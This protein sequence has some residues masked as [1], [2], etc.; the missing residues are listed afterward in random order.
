MDLKDAKA[1]LGS[2]RSP[3]K[4]ARKKEERSAL[5]SSMEMLDPL[6]KLR[7]CLSTGV[8][9]PA[10]LLIPECI[11][12]A[13]QLDDCWKFASLLSTQEKI[14]DASGALSAYQILMRAQSRPQVKQWSKG[15]LSFARLWKAGTP[16]AQPSQATA[17]TFLSAVAHLLEHRASLADWTPSKG[18][19]P[20]ETLTTLVGISLELVEMYPTPGSLALGAELLAQAVSRHSLDLDE[21]VVSPETQENAGAADVLWRSLTAE[22][23]RAAIAIRLGDLQVLL[24]AMD[25]FPGKKLEFQASVAELLT[26]P[27][28]LDRACI[29]VISQFADSAG[30]DDNSLAFAPGLHKEIETTELARVLMKAWDASASLISGEELAEEVTTTLSRLFGLRLIGEVGRS[31]PYRPPIHEF[32]TGAAIADSVR[33]V[34]PGVQKASADSSSVVFKAIVRAAKDNSNVG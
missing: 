29:Q 25:A 21:L 1:R 33:V 6:E 17:I 11:S 15:L 19:R 12:S 22:L 9:P 3:I 18:A 2:L 7:L 5:L 28:D 8:R 27:E 10:E 13:I 16:H 4:T 24:R 32:E 14:I 30:Q 34:R 20:G 23:K 26:K 31:V